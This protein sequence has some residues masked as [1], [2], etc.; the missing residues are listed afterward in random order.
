MIDI[1]QDAGI[2]NTSKPL[3]L[4]RLLKFHSLV[5][6]TSVLNKWTFIKDYS[7]YLYLVNGQLEEMW[8]SDVD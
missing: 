6:E 8:K 4:C 5:T 3:R 1:G 7:L 2:W